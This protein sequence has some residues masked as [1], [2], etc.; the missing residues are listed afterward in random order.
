M[1][2]VAWNCNRAAHKK[3][4]ALLRLRP[5]VVVLSE[6][7]SPRVKAAEP[8]FA[9]ASSHLWTGAVETQGLAV[10]AFGGWSLRPLPQGGRGSLAIPLQVEGPASFQLLALWTQAP[11]YVEQAHA[12]LDGHSDLFESGPTVVAGD[13]NSNAIWDR[14][15]APRNHTALTQRLDDHGLF[16]AYHAHREE[17]Q[18]VESDPTFFSHRHVH[19]PFHLDYVFLPSAWRHLVRRRCRQACGLAW[20]ERPHAGGGGRRSW[21]GA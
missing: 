8:V 15:H 5:D 17:S 20:V 16:S 13:L 9:P 14:Q 7:A 21:R 12:A 10:L 2:L 18:G 6:C 4:G 1:R 19:R 3:L 11:G